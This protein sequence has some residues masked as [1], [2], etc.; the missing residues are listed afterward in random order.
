MK[1]SK[2]DTDGQC[3]T[4]SQEK[5]LAE[6]DLNPSRLPPGWVKEVVF[7]KTKEGT[8]IVMQYYTDPLSNYTF[9]TL[10][11]AVGYLETKELPKLAF[12]QNTSVHDVYNFEKFADL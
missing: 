12:I 7:R 4:S 6:V 11:S 8:R 1:I 5:I 10:K 9:R 2:C 3:D